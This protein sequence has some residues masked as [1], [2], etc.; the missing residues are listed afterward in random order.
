MKS[1]AAIAYFAGSSAL[2]ALLTA[3]GGATPPASTPS[4][5]VSLQA[6]G[7]IASLPMRSGVTKRSWMSPAAKSE[8]IIY[9]SQLANP[10]VF[11]F[12]ATTF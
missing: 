7:R 5:P 9:V 10:G 8:G 6:I 2:V 11:G 1:A 3:C 4:G 12:S